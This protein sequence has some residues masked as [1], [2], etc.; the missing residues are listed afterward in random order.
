MRNNR[1]LWEVFLVVVKM[2]PTPQKPYELWGG[3]AIEGLWETPFKSLIICL[4]EFSIKPLFA[5][6]QQFGN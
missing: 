6:I 5:H 2:F 3:L 4:V 1:R